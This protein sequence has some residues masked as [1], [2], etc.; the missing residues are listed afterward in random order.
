MEH[1]YSGLAPMTAV[2]PYGQNRSYLRARNIKARAM[3]A[4]TPN[5]HIQPVFHPSIPYPCKELPP[6]LLFENRVRCQTHF[7]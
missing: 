7:F 4:T 2:S 3:I 1:S 5:I 6:E